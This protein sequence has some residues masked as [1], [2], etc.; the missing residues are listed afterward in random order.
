M[1]L[2]RREYR[3]IKPALDFMLKAFNVRKTLFIMGRWDLSY[4]LYIMNANNARA[5]CKTYLDYQRQIIGFVQD[6][7]Q[8]EEEKISSDEERVMSDK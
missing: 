7:I 6:L 1:G 4:F 8:K 3:H 5:F 2:L